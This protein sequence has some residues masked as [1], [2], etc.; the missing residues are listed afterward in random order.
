[1]EAFREGGP[2]KS[3]GAGSRLVWTLLTLLLDDMVVLVWVVQ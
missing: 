3:A 1:L 2:T